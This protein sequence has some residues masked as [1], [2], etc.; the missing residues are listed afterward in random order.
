MAPRTSLLAGA[1]QVICCFMNIETKGKKRSSGVQR[2]SMKAASEAVS[3][4]KGNSRT[5]K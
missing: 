3:P 5:M 1:A 2:A 4:G